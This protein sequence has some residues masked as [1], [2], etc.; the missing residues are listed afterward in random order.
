MSAKSLIYR[1]ELKPV[2]I[3]LVLAGLQLFITLF[4]NNFALSLDEAMAH[5]IGR[6]WFR[7]GLAPYSGGADNKS[8]FFYAV[9]GLSDVL[10]G[11]NYWF[12]RVLGTVCQ[13]IGIYYL[14]KIARYLAG[15]QAGVLAIS[16]YGLS[17]L[18]H[19]TDARYTSYTETFDVL[20]TILSVYYFITATNN[21]GYLISG[22]LA[23][24]ALA[25]R[26]SAVFAIITLLIASLYRRGVFTLMFCAGLLAGIFC[27]A[28][29]C[30]LA[31]IN[32]Q[33]VYIYALTDN[34]GTGSTSDHY[35]LWK[36]E[37]GFNMFFYSEMVLFYP[38]VIGYI[39]ITKKINW[40]IVWI[41]LAVIGINIIGNYARVHLKDLLPALALAS[42][43]AVAY[44][45][46]TYKLPLPYIMLAV[47]VCFFPKLL[48]PV[49]TFK[50]VFL[51]EPFFAENYTRAP[52]MIPDEG[53]NRKLGLWVRNNTPVNQKVFIAGFG[54]QIQ[55]Y[56]ERV[57]P[58]IYFNVTQTQI[59]KHRFYRDIQQNK[60]GMIL[61]PMFP[62]YRQ[63]VGA[64][65]LGYIDSV[66]A[67]NYTLDT[68]LYSYNIYKIK[69]K[70]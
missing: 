52:F 24:V 12:P 44:V 51:P 42:A 58:T 43:I 22:L 29:I 10:F 30:L 50:R 16:F 4:S 14:Y 41:I 55:A 70:E 67:K 13:S 39:I 36:F 64:D 61:V 53:L 1:L 15:E 27:L 25:F 17:L 54:G 45:T 40:L 26:L 20:F 3:I 31:G 21:K 49:V 65:L 62:Q 2:Q 34:F 23:A 28:A 19:C 59:A 9:Y 37:Q 6:N 38:L 56:T 8:P 63:Y 46:D 68:C 11:V 69:S 47:W 18:W 57:S 32:L 48:E 60:P 35:L 5:Y 33:E 7:N 66:V